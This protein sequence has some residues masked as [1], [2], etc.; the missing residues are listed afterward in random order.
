M[1]KNVILTLGHLLVLLHELPT[2]L[3]LLLLLSSSSSSS[4]PGVESVIL[5]SVVQEARISPDVMSY[6]TPGAVRCVV[7]RVEQQSTRL[8]T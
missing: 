2:E 8:V 7:H 1:C 4:S 3:L 6:A 5:T